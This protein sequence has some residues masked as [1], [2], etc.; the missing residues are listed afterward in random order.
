MELGKNEKLKKEI[1]HYE[2]AAREAGRWAGKK[3]K[4]KTGHRIGGLKP[5]RGAIGHK[6]AKMMKRS[7]VLEHRMERA[8]RE[9]AG[10]LKNIEETEALKMFPLVYDK[11][12][13]VTVDDRFWHSVLISRCR[14]ILHLKVKEIRYIRQCGI[15]L[16]G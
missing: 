7:K 8:A 10:L 13:L 15:L 12:R 6:A 11:E 2:D 5:D 4:E 1:R 9:K 3:E 16:H 14:E